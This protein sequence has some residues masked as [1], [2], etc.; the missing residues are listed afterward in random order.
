MLVG[1]NPVGLRELNLGIIFRT[2]Q[3]LGPLSQTDIVQRTNLA[4]ST[5]SVITGELRDQ[6]L[7]RSTGTIASSGGRR[8]VLLEVNP[9]GG[10]FI[11]VDLVGTQMAIGV[12]DLTFA[13]LEEWHFEMRDTGELLYQVVVQSIQSVVEQCSALALNILGIGVA[14]P[15]LLD[16]ETGVIVEADN[17]GWY[18][19]HLAERLEQTFGVKTVVEHDVNAAAYGEYLYG[20]SEGI[21]NMM[22]V[23]IGLGIG[24]GLILDGHLFSGSQGLA[25]ELGHVMV[26]P[27]GSACLCGKRGCLETLASGKA[28]AL[29][30]Q[31]QAQYMRNVSDVAVAEVYDAR[32]VVTRAQAGDTLAQSVVDKAGGAVGVALGNQINVLNVDRIILGGN[33]VNS[34]SHFLGAIRKGIDQALLPRLRDHVQIHTSSLGLSSGFVGIAFLCFGKLFTAVN[35]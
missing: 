19:L 5:V 17:L 33:L 26:D 15:G 35:I 32:D 13:V 25:G 30:Y 12:L 23:S 24:C 10:C 16:A 4:P 7:I 9:E 1:M 8:R 34:S 14:A 11:C 20:Q 28:I 18:E 27:D 31:K 3:T 29:E 22:Y 2:I 21:R 6:R